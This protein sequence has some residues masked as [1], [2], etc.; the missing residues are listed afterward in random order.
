MGLTLTDIA[1]DIP[2]VR[3]VRSA[4]CD[5]T[6]GFTSAAKASSMIVVTRSERGVTVHLRG[7][8]TAGTALTCP[9]GSEIFGVEFAIV[10]RATDRSSEQ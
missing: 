9:A 8:E 10:P 4:S 7:P 3:R 1:G 6:T 2:L 5:A